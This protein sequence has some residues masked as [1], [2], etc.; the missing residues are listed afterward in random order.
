ML[1]PSQLLFTSLVFSL[2]QTKIKSLSWFTCTN[3]I[4]PFLAA[5]RVVFKH[6]DNLAEELIRE[7]FKRRARSDPDEW[8]NFSVMDSKHHAEVFHNR[9][10]TTPRGLPSSGLL[11]DDGHQGGQSLQK[12]LSRK[13][14][15][16][17][18][19]RTTTRCC[20]RMARSSFPEKTGSTTMRRTRSTGSA[21]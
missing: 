2:Y 19:P 9:G 14:T 5:H 20:T 15:G 17:R 3:A 16:S 18:N 12:G 10:S 7:K 8:D 21:P 11:G 1:L 6:S 4:N 13:S